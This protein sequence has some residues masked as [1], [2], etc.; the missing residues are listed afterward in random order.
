M[1][2][3]MLGDAQHV[4]QVINYTLA[5]FLSFAFC[6]SM[7]D[8]C[9]SIVIILKQ[10]IGSDC[11]FILYCILCVVWYLNNLFLFILEKIQIAFYVLYDILITVWYLDNRDMPLLHLLINVF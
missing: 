11:A 6:W 10:F 2:V 1:R 9:R 8:H 5:I 3:C 4:D 7:F